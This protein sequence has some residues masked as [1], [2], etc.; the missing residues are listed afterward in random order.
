MENKKEFAVNP[1]VLMLLGA[2]FALTAT[3]NVISAVYVGI[4]VTVVTLISQIVISV[5]KNALNKNGQFAVTMLLTAGLVSIVEMLSKA[6][7]PQVY[8]MVS[9]YVSLLAVNLI[10]LYCCEESAMV[11]GVG[12]AAADALVSGLCFTLC[13]FV[14]AFVREVFGAGSFAGNAISVLSGHTVPLLVKNA[15]G[16]MILAFVMAIA[17]AIFPAE[18]VSFGEGLV[19]NAVFDGNV[20][21]DR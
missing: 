7:L 2:T 6:Y 11:R 19:A 3:E 9:V 14:I 18:R 10:T 20:K 8:S 21:E 15:G 5:L 13:L 4:V 12:A 17:N 1:T 16:Y